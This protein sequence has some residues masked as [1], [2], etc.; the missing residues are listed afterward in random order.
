MEF[1]SKCRKTADNSSNLHI[2]SGPFHEKLPPKDTFW[3]S[4]SSLLIIQSRKNFEKHQC[5]EP[6][7]PTLCWQRDVWNRSVSTSTWQAHTNTNRTTRPHTTLDSTFK[8]IKQREF[9]L[10]S[11]GCF[12]AFER[13]ARIPEQHCISTPGKALHQLLRGLLI[14]CAYYES[15]L[16]DTASLACYAA[17]KSVWLVRMK[18]AGA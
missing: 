14:H 2:E 9:E 8:A 11:P 10:G 17:W 4:F 1:S 18:N 16:T 13:P 5:F 12:G 3:C 7:M 6:I 15:F